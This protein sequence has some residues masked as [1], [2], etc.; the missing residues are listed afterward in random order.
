VK[1]GEPNQWTEGEQRILRRLTTPQAIQC[2]LDRLPYSSEKTYHCP[3]SVMRDRKAHC[4]DGAVFAAA[5]LFEIGHPPLILELIP[6][7]RDDD[8]LIALFR[9]GSLWGAVSKSNFA[10]LR[11]RE[12]V[13]PTLHALVLSYFEGFFNLARERT[14]R[15]FGAPLSLAR[16]DRA[17]WRIAD[18]TMFAIARELDHCR[19]S[20]LVTPAM[21]RRMTRVDWRTFQAGTVGMRRS[22]VYKPKKKN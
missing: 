2:Y 16:F 10:L 11:Y 7:R 13:Y 20:R 5:A 6:N 4:F 3:R 22:G 18:S 12:P 21:A 14:L 17:G 15:A 9:A 1:S 19:R 8:H